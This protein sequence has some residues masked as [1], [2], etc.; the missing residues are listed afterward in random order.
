MAKGSCI[1]NEVLG[2]FDRTGQMPW[3]IQVLAF[4]M[5]HIVGFSMFLLK[6]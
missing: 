1:L 2:D 4:Y 6:F 3:L 5:S